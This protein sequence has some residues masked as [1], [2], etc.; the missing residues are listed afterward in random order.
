MT[1]HTAAMRLG[2]DRVAPAVA[3]PRPAGEFH[4]PSLDGI[5]AISFLIVFVAHAGWSEAI[6]GGFGVTVF[7]F[8]SGY[9]ITT[10][11]RME[12]DRTGRVSLR[13]FYLRRVLRILPPFYTVL[14]FAISL[15]LLGVLGGTL[16]LRPVLAQVVHVTNYW[17]V[18]HGA[19]GQPDGTAVYWSLAVEEHF[20]LLFPCLFILLQ[21]AL[22]SR[23]RPQATILLG[24]CAAVAAW[25]CVLVFQFHAPMDRT[26]LATD[27]RVDSIL[28]GCALALGGN[29]VL[30][31]ARVP[32]AVTRRA[33]LPAAALLLTFTFV[34]R[35]PWFRETIRYT[36]QGIALWPIFVAAVR[37]PRLGPFR[38][39][40]LPAVRHLGA[41]S[42]SLYL[43][44]FV[45]LN[46]IPVAPFG[47]LLHGLFGLAAAIAVSEMIH[48]AIEKPCARLRRRLGHAGPSGPAAPRARP[49]ACGAP[50]GPPHWDARLPKE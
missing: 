4:I 35:A 45:I 1:L 42:Y 43:V 25:R 39:L 47:R 22:P 2:P 20:Y 17:N 19:D 10:L 14:A 15:S 24:L 3:G 23:F 48:R 38:V 49:T 36:L 27:T 8:L 9:L 28:F 5:R 30:D 12:H 40:N 31:Q 50:P 34:Y 44:H 11:L 6:P 18:L 41:L 37:E 13:D 16:Q 33:L 7:F 26:Y 32:A 29:P 46:A 21:R